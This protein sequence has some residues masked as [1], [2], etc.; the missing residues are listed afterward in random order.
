MSD[1]SF[2]MRDSSNSPRPSERGWGEAVPLLL[3]SY[4]PELDEG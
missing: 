1:E 3:H 4:T 2:K